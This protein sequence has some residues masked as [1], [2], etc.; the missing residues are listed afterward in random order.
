MIISKNPETQ[1][2]G[3]K[4]VEVMGE[5]NEVITH[6]D[7]TTMARNYKMES[8]MADMKGNVIFDP[9]SQL[10]RE[11]MFEMILNAFG[12]E[13]ELMEVGMEGKGFDQTIQLLFGENGFFP[14]TLFK[15]MNWA[16]DKMPNK[17]NEVLDKWTEPLK[18]ERQKRQVPENIV[19][20]IVRNV[21]KLVKDIQAQEAP[22]ATAY[23]KLFGDELGYIKGSELK[24]IVN[25]AAMYADTLIRIIPTKVVGQLLAGTDNELF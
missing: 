6:V 9:S 8:S 7:Y 17:I 22:E 12:Y 19:R 4:V 20:E 10:P 25:T 1:K 2:W 13:Q 5:E 11:V 23:L 15:T 14:D 18:S 3:K 16:Q 21:N 24:S